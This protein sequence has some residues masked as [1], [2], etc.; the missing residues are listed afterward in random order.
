LPKVR[1]TSPKKAKAKSY[2]HPIPDRNTLLEYL[3]DVG[4][5]RRANAILKDFSIKAAK[6]RTQ[7]LEK[8]SALVRA[9]QII[10]NRGGEYCLS[11]KL[12]LIS[13]TVNAHKDGFGFVISDQGG[14]DVYLS[15][16]EMRSFRGTGAPARIE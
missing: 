7:L 9:G 6:G 1:K 4:Q 8:L 5:P 2:K 10:Q 14:D 11:E 12:D 13:G 16:R 15:A 3:R